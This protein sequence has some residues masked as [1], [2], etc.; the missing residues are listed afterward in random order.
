MSYSE[1]ISRNNAYYA[2]FYD[3]LRNRTDKR[4]YCELLQLFTSKIKNKE[5]VILDIGSGLGQHL[6]Y[7]KEKGFK[8]IGIEPSPVLRNLCEQSGLEVI[9]GSFETLATLSLPKIA[10]IWCAASLLHVPLNEVPLAAQTMSGLLEQD[11]PLFVT[12]RTG[13][14]GYWDN[15]DSNSDVKRFIQLFDPAELINIFSQHNLN[16]QYKRLEDSYWGRKATWYS[17]IFTR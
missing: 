14:E 9:D 6:S 16:E 2:L 3:N 5:G 7:F 11:D 10:G 4:N 1:R 13:S 17:G 15:Y 12:V 8:A